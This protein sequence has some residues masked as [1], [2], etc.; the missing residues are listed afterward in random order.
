MIVG[1]HTCLAHDTTNRARVDY[2]ILPEFFRRADTGLGRDT[3]N[4][5]SPQQ[6]AL[7]GFRRLRWFRSRVLSLPHYPFNWY[8]KCALLRLRI[9]AIGVV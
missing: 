8:E 6:A 7:R 4:V 3:P 9:V 5:G 2:E 1:G